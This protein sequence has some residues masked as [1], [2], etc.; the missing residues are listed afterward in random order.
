MRGSSRIFLGLVARVAR[1]AN[2]SLNSLCRP[3]TNPHFLNDNE[4]PTEKLA[5]QLSH[6]EGRSFISKPYQML[7]LSQNSPFDRDSPFTMVGVALIQLSV[8]LARSTRQITSA[9]LILLALE[10]VWASATNFDG[11]LFQAAFF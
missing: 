5:P 11:M 7:I 3:I 4:C 1:Y 2:S 9:L 8:H 6:L 10:T